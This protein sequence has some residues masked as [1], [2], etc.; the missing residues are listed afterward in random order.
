MK[1]KSFL[2][3][4]GTLGIFSFAAQDTFANKLQNDLQAEVVN[5]WKKS[6]EMTMT[7]IGQMPEDFFAFKYTPEAMSF[8]EQFR[9]CAVFTYGQMS[10]RLGA[11]NPFENAKPAVQLS[12]AETIALTEQLYDTVIGWASDMDA[13]KMLEQTD[14]S[15]EQMPVWRLFYAMENHIIHHRG[16]AVVY[17]RLNGIRPKGYFGW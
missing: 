16:Q 8:A 3:R 12:K 1:R 6:K 11:K 10:G 17:L 9:H 4:L 13:Q 15:G 5:A 7:T 14:F 2:K